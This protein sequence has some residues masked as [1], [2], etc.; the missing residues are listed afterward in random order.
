MS[1]SGWTLSRIQQFREEVEI[2][3]RLRAVEREHKMRKLLGDD[4]YGFVKATEE[5]GGL[6]AVLGEPVEDAQPDPVRRAHAA[7]S[8][9]LEQVREILDQERGEKP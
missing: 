5:A 7:I 3:S 1:D 2:D 4:V 8:A 9:A 6:E